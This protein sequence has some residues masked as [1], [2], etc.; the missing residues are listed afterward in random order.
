MV[1]ENS[2]QLVEYQAQSLR[3]HH[4]AAVA[5]IRGM[6]EIAYRQD[7]LIVCF[8]RLWVAWIDLMTA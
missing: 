7:K 2:R 1:A 5:N 3:L 6:A 8:P 4:E